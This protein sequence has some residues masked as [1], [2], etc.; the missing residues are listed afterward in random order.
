M[1]HEEAL[2]GIISDLC[3]I[4]MRGRDPFFIIFAEGFSYVMQINEFSHCAEPAK[5]ASE[6]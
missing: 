6:A 3:K 4:C 2:I 5:F 1:L